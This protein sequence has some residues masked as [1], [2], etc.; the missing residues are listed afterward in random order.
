MSVHPWHAPDQYVNRCVTVH[1]S[2]RRCVRDVNHVGK[3]MFW[4][5]AGDQWEWSEA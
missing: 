2:E 3:H 5:N 1:E 4:D